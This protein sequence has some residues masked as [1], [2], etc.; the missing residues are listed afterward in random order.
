MKE[1]E[2]CTTQSIIRIIYIIYY[3]TFDQNIQYNA[4]GCHIFAVCASSRLPGN[5]I[6]LFEYQC[7][8]TI[9]IVFF[10]IEISWSGGAG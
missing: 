9:F 5:V 1:Y 6:H 4:A 2:R 7:Q 10:D 8:P 3:N